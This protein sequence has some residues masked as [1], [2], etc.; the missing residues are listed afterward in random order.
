M[1]EP[2]WNLRYTRM[3]LG[4]FFQYLTHYT[5]IAALS[6]FVVRDLGLGGNQAGLALTF[7]QIGAVLF[8]PF[9]GKWMDDF[10]KSKVLFAT[11]ALFC[12]VCFAYLG[13]KA[14]VFLLILR[15]VHGVA[16]STGTTATATMVA[17]YSPASRKGEGIGYLAVFTSVAMVIGPFIGLKLINEYSATLLFAACAFFGL[18]GFF[19][20]AVR[21]LPQ[22][23]TE[24]PA[25]KKSFRWQNLIEPNALPIA[26][27]GGLLAFVYS[28]LLG[29]LPLFAHNLGMMELASYFF[30]VYALAIILSR[31]FIGRLFDRVGPRTVVYAAALIYLA[32][33]AGLSQVE[34]PGAF[35]L[36]GA[37]TGLG[38]A[39]LNPSFQTLAVLAAP[40]DKSG[41]ATSTYFLFMDI[42]IGLGSFVLGPVAE[43][44]GYRAMYLGCSLLVIAIA[45]L[46]YAV[47]RRLRTGSAYT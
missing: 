44:A 7:F 9:A 22:P 27:C 11:S 38:F 6:V 3:C 23:K 5:L 1:K 34:S 43:F 24:A 8:R 32:G 35:L 4:N 26:C 20:S 19:C 45:A 46:F 28:S 30:A 25:Q 42:G 12:L 31:P 33:M 47:S 13:A 14:V 39:G 29:F 36:A 15:F 10:D 37:V 21:V 2:L 41:L 16:F 17:V 40:P 18:A